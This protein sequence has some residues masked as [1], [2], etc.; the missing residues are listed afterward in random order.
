MTQKYMRNILLLLCST[1]LLTACFGSS[2][3][4]EE[5]VQQQNMQLRQLQSAQ[6]DAQIQMQ[7][8]TEENSTL[9]GQLSDLQSA[10]GARALVEKVN[11]Q[12]A[13]L[14]QVENSMALDL[15]LGDPLKPQPGTMEM[16]AAAGDPTAPVTPNANAANG[17]V[18]GTVAAPVSMG[19]G[20]SGLP[21]YG[22]TPP[23]QSTAPAASPLNGDIK[24]WPGA[25]PAGKAPSGETWGQA[26]PQPEAPAP[27][28]DIA[29]ALYDAGVNDFQARKYA[30]AERSFND[31][32]KNYK[33]HNL[34]GDA[35]FYLA[36]CSF[37]RNQ[38]SDAA[39]AYQD[40][41]T[42]FP[43]SAKV[44]AAYLKQGISFSKVGQKA[45][46]QARL[47]ELIKKY[48]RSAEAQRAKSFLKTNK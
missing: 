34:A 9:K 13:A 28:K 16:P 32:L 2:A 22:Q 14:R 30:E 38:F 27:Q 40:V 39:L 43:K 11:Q 10:G 21:T 17:E 15:K 37:Q 42:K 45:A 3:R 48:P 7:A 23:A 24:P 20:N 31:F 18:A 35:Q 44:P 4:L 33:G 41:I 29:Q 12:D 6:A 5:Q 1:C 8:L 25:T 36:E 19:G 47:N 46:A 26:T